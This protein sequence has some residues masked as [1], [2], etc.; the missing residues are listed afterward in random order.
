MA[1]ERGVTDSSP[2][3]LTPALDELQREALQSETLSSRRISEIASW[4]ALKIAPVVFTA[5][6]ALYSLPLF[7]TLS[8]AYG[9]EN[10]STPT[11]VAERI[12]TPESRIAA[13]ENPYYY[14][15]K[16]GINQ[17]VTIYHGTDGFGS[18]NPLRGIDTFE[19]CEDSAQTQTWTNCVYFQPKETLFPETQASTDVFLVVY[20]IVVKRFNNTD[21]G[22][23]AMSIPNYP[24]DLNVHFPRTL[25]IGDMNNV[26]DYSNQSE[27]HGGLPQ[28][29]SYGDAFNSISISE[30][31]LPEVVLGLQRQQNPIYDGNYMS[32]LDKGKGT[33]SSGFVK[34]GSTPTP[35]PILTMTPTLT[36]TVTAT[37]ATTYRVFVPVVWK[38]ITTAS[39]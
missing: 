13:L 22:F 28:G 1:V 27:Y 7:Q 21:V 38:N 14:V 9:A 3:V 39:W 8:S 29:G 20:G 35:T 11:P 16:D 36:P 33:Y 26:T 19:K 12:F 32:N 2:E 10:S 37:W 6:L 25:R 15:S 24:A 31:S 5:G 23:A 17:R 18:N 30:G 4:I 34:E